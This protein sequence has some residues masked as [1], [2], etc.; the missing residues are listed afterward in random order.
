MGIDLWC[1][2]KEERVSIEIR[3]KGIGIGGG[4]ERK[5]FDKFYG[6]KDIGEGN[7][8]GIGVGVS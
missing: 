6:G 2:E 8:G 5:V 1:I 4:E 3:D 7:I